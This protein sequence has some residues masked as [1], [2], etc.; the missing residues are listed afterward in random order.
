[1]IMGTHLQYLTG[2]PL[3][4]AEDALALEPNSKAD[5]SFPVFQFSMLMCDGILIPTRARTSCARRFMRAEEPR[6]PFCC[7]CCET[8]F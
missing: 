6:R 5:D 7:C 1:M 3:F 8:A 2:N 4:L